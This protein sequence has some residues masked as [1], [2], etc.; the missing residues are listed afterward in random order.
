[1]EDARK[2]V[3]RGYDWNAITDITGIKPDDLATA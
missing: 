3:D 1:L 2:M